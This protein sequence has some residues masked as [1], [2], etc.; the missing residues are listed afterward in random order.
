MER[1]SA[2]RSPLAMALIAVAGALLVVA[3]FPGR[4]LIRGTEPGADQDRRTISVGGE[5]RVT[6]TPDQ[7]R[8]ELGVILQRPTVKEAQAVAAEAMQ[9]VVAS[10]RANGI[11]DEKI[12]TST[13]SLQPVYEYPNNGGAPKIV[14]YS[15]AN[16]VAV[17]VDDLEKLGPVIDDAM[18]AGATTVGSIAF[19]VADPAAATQQARAAAFADARSHAEALASAAGVRVGKVLSISESGSP[20]PVVWRDDRAAGEGTPIL[21]GTSQVTVTVSIVYEIGS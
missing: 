18:T 16:I 7:A 2:V 12:Q 4:D 10:I 6:V 19:T 13:F 3:L 17:T 5:G 9:K 8:L 1:T 21:P 11:A 15:I 20:P 14:G